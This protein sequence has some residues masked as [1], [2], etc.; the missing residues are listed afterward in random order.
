MMMNQF[1][2]L[3]TGCL[4]TTLVLT[5]ASAANAL[6]PDDRNN[7]NGA[8]PSQA[9]QHTGLLAELE[10]ARSTVYP[11]LV[12]ISVVA[13]RFSGGR[14]QR[15]PGAGSGV[16]ISPEGHVLTNYHVVRNATRIICRRSDGKRF[17]AKVLAED[18]LT[19]LSVLQLDL[20]GYDGTPPYASLGDSDTLG[21][22]D[23]VLAMGN[24]LALSSSMTLGIVSNAQRVFTDFTG[25]EIQ[26][27][28]FAGQR[29]GIFT[30]WIQHDSLILPGNSGGPLVNLKGE[31]IGIN[32]RGGGGVGFAIPANEAQRVLDLVLE[33][34]E[35][36]RAWLGVRILP[37]EKLGHDTGA[38][39]SWVLP[40]SPAD[41][42]G[43]KAGDRLLAI[44]GEEVSA[45]FFEQVPAVY[46]RIANNDIDSTI[47]IRFAR[48]GKEQ[49]TEAKLVRMEPDVGDEHEVRAVGVTVRDI[50]GPMALAR[51]LPT[52]DAV[53]VT[54][55][56]PGYPFE[57]ARPSV[58]SGDVIVELNHREALDVETFREIVADLDE[59]TGSVPVR[60]FREDEEIITVINPRRDD[61]RRAGGE[62]PRAWLGVETQVLTSN[63]ADALDLEGTRGFRV[64]DVF[65]GTK[66]ADAGLKRGDVITAVDGIDLAAYREQDRH[67]LRRL[68]EEFPIG[69]TVD[70]TI[71]RGGEQQDIPVELEGTPD[72]AAEMERTEQEQLEF[73]VR[74]IAFIDGIKQRWPEGAEGVIVTDVTNGG[75]AHVAG[76][77]I[78]D[79]IVSIQDQT[80][81]SVEAFEGAMR[82]IMEA[83]PEVIRLFVHRGHRTHFVFIEP[84][85][86]Q[87]FK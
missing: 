55:V 17:D 81:E 60:L 4:A 53:F 69:D 72:D 66:A 30:Q 1:R 26:E 45:V 20:T 64:T 12:N 6:S 29:T 34:G 58:R 21:V 73:T 74:E 11:A 87:I 71:I 38:L 68:I 35:V 50:T 57:E 5:S 22:G 51:Q 39:I 16:I 67:E 33:H 41:D 49:T 36:P 82:D 86:E 2:P 3:L 75:W 28:D 27:F 80:T 18:P 77:R 62:L 52:T 63:V 54:G 85:W 84:D 9:M 25:T 43:L 31:V 15:G 83:R 24:P 7:A 47:E 56:R 23:F 40:D 76:L 70:I 46:R 79:L 37:V 42:A 10:Q 78:D 8:E 13:Q 44:N 14:A 61:R 19:D 32:A 48:N 65:R 59:D